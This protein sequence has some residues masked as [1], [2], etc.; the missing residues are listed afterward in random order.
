MKSRAS[1]CSFDCMQSYGCN[2][3]LI[4]I[5]FCA[6][7]RGQKSTIR[8]VWDK[9]PITASLIF[10]LRNAFS[11]GRFL[12]HSKKFGGFIVAFNR[13]EIG[14]AISGSPPFLPIP[15]TRISGWQKFLIIAL[16]WALSNKNNSFK[17]LKV[18]REDGRDLKTHQ[19]T[20][21]TLFACHIVFIEWMTR[22]QD[23]EIIR[24]R[25]KINFDVY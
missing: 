21:S 17:S 7:I 16:F 4:L 8:F 12:H 9:N 14:I 20:S 10:H 18:Y 11:M 3:D 25:Y 5:K 23:S 1:I 19:Q 22:C 15:N 13:A 24:L 2:F 6:S